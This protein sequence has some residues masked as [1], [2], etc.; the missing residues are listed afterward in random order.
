MGRPG[1]KRTVTE[2]EF[3][4]YDD[5][6]YALKRCTVPPLRDLDCVFSGQESSVFIGFLLISYIGAACLQIVKLLVI[7][8]NK[9]TG[10]LF[11]T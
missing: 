4:L 8:I 6:E 7:I 3:K 2:A 9:Q 5:P 1:H 11:E 10:L